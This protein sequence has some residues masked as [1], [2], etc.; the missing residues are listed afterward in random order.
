M[1]K[2]IKYKINGYWH[3]IAVPIDGHI[4]AIQLVNNEEPSDIIE[5][6]LEAKAVIKS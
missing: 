4:E 3:E 5:E 1:N 6:T 2:T